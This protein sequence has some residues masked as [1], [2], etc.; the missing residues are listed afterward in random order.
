MENI[1]SRKVTTVYGIN[2]GFGKLSSVRIAVNEHES[3]QRNLIRSHAVGIGPPLNAEA[4]RL[5]TLLKILS[6]CQGYSGV[7]MQVVERLQAFLNGD[8]LPIIPSQGSVG[9]AVPWRPWR[10]LRWATSASGEFLR[11][12][13]EM[14]VYPLASFLNRV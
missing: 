11:C 3:L 4:V 12:S 7:R 10:P 9:A 5:T 14:P 2:T 1:L 8:I 13:M 6:L